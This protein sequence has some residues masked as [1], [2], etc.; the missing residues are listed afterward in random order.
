MDP[1]AASRRAKVRSLWAFVLATEAA[2]LGRV[3]DVD[4]EKEEGQKWGVE[5]YTCY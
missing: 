2:Q 4:Q 5:K 3:E 1:G